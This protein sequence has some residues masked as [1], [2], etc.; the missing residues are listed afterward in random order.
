[1]PKNQITSQQ[2]PCLKCLKKYGSDLENW[3]PCKNCPWT[4][5]EE[6]EDP[7]IQQ[8]KANEKICL[9]CQEALKF[10]E[11]KESKYLCGKN[12]CLREYIK[13]KNEEKCS[14]K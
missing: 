11:V 1:M 5:K 6:L 4:T 2:E 13:R 14:S 10:L 9:E 3:E 8:K 7:L 12:K